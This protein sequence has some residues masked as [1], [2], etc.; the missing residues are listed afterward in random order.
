MIKLENLSVQKKK[1]FILK[2]INLQILPGEKIWLQGES[3]SGKSTLIKSILFFE[4]F[5]GRVLYNGIPVDENNLF[6]FRSKISYVGQILPKF[7]STVREFLLLPFTYKSNQKIAFNELK[8]KKLFK[9]LNFNLS[10]LEEKFSNLSGGEKQRCVILQ[11]LMLDKD[12]YLFDEITSNLDQKNIV[13]AIS[14]ITKARKKTVI[15]ISHNQEW[16]KYC[17]RKWI[18]KKG[19]MVNDLVK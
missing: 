15:S 6:D 1:K 10:V 12:I 19:K 2:N 18:L 8:M 11:V 3:G 16:D 4:V 13:R 17:N 9:S 14:L 5:S 7:D